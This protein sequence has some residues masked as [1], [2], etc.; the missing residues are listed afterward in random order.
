MFRRSEEK[1]SKGFM[2]SK[3]EALAHDVNVPLQGTVG[4]NGVWA[5]VPMVC[6]C[7]YD[8]VVLE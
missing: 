6:G 8:G 2:F 4:N 7:Q 3:L 5:L 1:N